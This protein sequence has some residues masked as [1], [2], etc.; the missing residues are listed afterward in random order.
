MGGHCIIVYFRNEY[1]TFFVYSFSKND[2]SNISDKE[3]KAF[4]D[5][6]KEDFELTDT[7]IR[8]W[9]NRGTLIEITEEDFH[10]VA[11]NSINITAH[12]V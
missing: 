12:A 4:K 10:R 3:L 6:A 8:A 7:E 11:M 5:D 2:R 1:R 9:L